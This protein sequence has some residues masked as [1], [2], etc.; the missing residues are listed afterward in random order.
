MAFIMDDINLLQ[1]MGYDVTVA[2]G[3]TEGEERLL[4]EIQRRGARFVCIDC[5]S[6][7]PLGAA[8]R[9]ALRRYRKL[10]K[11]ERFDAVFCH[12]PIVGMLV[13]LGA[14]GLRKYIRKIAYVSHGFTWTHLSDT[15][16]RLKFRTV[17]NLLSPLGDAIITINNEDYEQAR[18][19]HC[20]RV[21]KFDGVGCDV[22]AI[23][24]A[25]VDRDAVRD[26]LG[27]GKNDIMVLAM[28]KI[29]L[30]KNH[31]A[32]LRGIATLPDKDR[33][34]FV[35]CGREFGGTSLTDALLAEARTSGVRL[36]LPG[37]QDDVAPMCHAADIGV[38][39]SRRE[40]LGMAGIEMLSAGVPL[41]GT[42]VQG[43]P[44]YINEA[45]VPYGN[46]KSV[47]HLGIVYPIRFGQTGELV[48]DPDDYVAFGQAIDGL[49][50]PLMREQMAP[51][52]REMAGRFSLEHSLEQRRK[53]YADIL[54]FNPNFLK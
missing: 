2:A 20:R 35:I 12:T 42:R 47:K 26:S 24:E 49:S 15:K 11:T 45:S 51:F 6:D 27:I 5:P 36:V 8:N 4:S 16:T 31:M 32:V 9:R 13:R 23:T 28:G 40:G 52:C 37:F 21:Y 43:I 3:A 30:L 25:K 22:S 41:V 10:M 29:S 19:M 39:P 18:A 48:D 54:G 33:Y 34:V 50:I 44:E 46:P 14:I 53:I 7:N 17:E 38:M 1:D